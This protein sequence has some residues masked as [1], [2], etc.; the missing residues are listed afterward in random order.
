MKRAVALV[1]AILGACT[2][3]AAHGGDPFEIQVYDGTANAPGVPG[4]ELHLNDWATGNRDATPPEVPLHGQFHATLEPSLGLLPFW[5]IGAYLQGAVRTDDG[6]ATF[7]GVKFRTKFV[8]PPG[9]DEHWRL[10]L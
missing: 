1:S 7:A 8:T 10:G 4:L 9:W 6:V 3:P 2:S 5:E